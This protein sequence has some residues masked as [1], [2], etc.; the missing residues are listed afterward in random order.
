MNPGLTDIDELRA[1]VRDRRSREILNEAILAYQSGALRAAVVSTWSAVAFDLVSKCRELAAGSDTEAAN[2]VEEIDR[3][4]T[5]EDVRK[6]ANLEANL[7]ERAGRRLE[8]LIGHEIVQLERLR[9]DRHRCAHPA[10]SSDEHLF[11]PS[12]EQVRSHFFSAVDCLLANPPVQ[13]RSMLARIKLDLL[14]PSFPTAEAEAVD[15]ATGRYFSNA[16]RSLL[17]AFVR[18]GVKEV[19]RSIDA[20]L[21]ESKRELY[22]CLLAVQKV[23]A[24]L[25]REALRGEL[26][27]LPDGMGDL[28]VGRV[29]ILL[30]SE[31]SSIAALDAP[32]R[33]RLVRVIGI[34]DVDTE[35]SLSVGFALLVPELREAA[36]SALRAA[37]L[38]VQAKILRASPQAALAED[39]AEIFLRSQ[40]FRQAEAFAAD[41]LLPYARHFSD[42]LVKKLLLG[43]PQNDQIRVAG[44]IPETLAEFYKLRRDTRERLKD[45]WRSFQATLIEKEGGD[46]DAPYAYQALRVLLESDGIW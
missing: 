12:A 9:D 24:H 20:D 1:R 44:G 35:R 3:A 42:E 25:Y 22:H 30:A 36:Q 8:I 11:Q 34:S 38:Q 13:G 45:D 14:Q 7:L 37:P 18:I 40:G 28:E 15:Y 5:S 26:A 31:P 21:A 17:E 27:R 19:V 43:I 39:A 16:R 23:D 41:L 46:A 10:F 6:L 33:A 2:L 4:T 29:A 32:L